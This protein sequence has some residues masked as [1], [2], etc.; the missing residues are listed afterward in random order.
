MKTV[1]EGIE[2]PAEARACA[3]LGFAYGQG[4]YIGRPRR[5]RG[6]LGSGG[7]GAAPPIGPRRAPPRSAPRPRRDELREQRQVGRDD[8]RD[9][10]VTAGRRAV[11]GHHDR[12]PVGR[13][14]D[15]P[16]TIPSERISAGRRAAAAR[17]RAGS[18]T[19]SDVAPT[20]QG[21]ARKR[22]TL[23]V[24]VV[25]LGA[26]H[27]AHGGATP[28]SAT[29]STR[30]PTR[31]AARATAS[32]R[33]PERPPAKPPNRRLQV[34]RPRAEDGGDVDAAGE[35]DVRAT[36]RAPAGEAQD[37]A[38]PGED[39]G[40]AR[41]RPWAEVGALEDGAEVAP[42]TAKRSRREEE[43]RRAGHG[44]LEG[45]GA[46][47]VADRAVGGRVGA[48]V[49]GPGAAHPDAAVAGTPAV[50][51]GRQQ[52]RLEHLDD[53]RSRGRG[54]R[55]GGSARRQLRHRHEAHAV[56]RGEEGR[57]LAEGVEEPA[58]RAAESCQPPGE[59]T[60]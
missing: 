27:H 45:G 51:H 43:E 3:E 1:A 18:P 36:A 57:L 34:G 59:A 2:T 53:R 40:A 55:D 29:A 9:L 54:P 50:L 12:P 49:H 19:R 23:G 17:P 11:G 28:R 21:S 16:G 39:A 25:G 58:R 26:E 15:E 13:H 4:F 30:R 44:A 24:E 22:A 38:G 7:H 5:D 8:R 20:R 33:P 31:P 6:A 41:H 48:G 10:R 35:G 47:R 37:V 46:G 32:G 52:P 60:G 14:L 56:A 42:A